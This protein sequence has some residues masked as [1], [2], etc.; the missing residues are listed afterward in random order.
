MNSP[1]SQKEAV[2]A[3]VYIY[4]TNGNINDKTVKIICNF[5]YIFISQYLQIQAYAY[6]PLKAYFLDLDYL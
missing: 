2:G 4:N 6:N 1:Q 5:L 3:I